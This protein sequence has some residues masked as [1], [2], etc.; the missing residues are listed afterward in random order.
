L[1]ELKKAGDA[2]GGGFDANDKIRQDEAMLAL[3]VSGPFGG[4]MEKAAARVKAK[5]YVVVARYDHVVTPESALEFAK[6]INAKVLVL[7]GDCG[8]QA[9]SC[10]AEKLNPSIAEFLKQ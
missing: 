8:H 6:L 9:P 2:K 5:V 7:E 4:S 1:E 10:E 3:D